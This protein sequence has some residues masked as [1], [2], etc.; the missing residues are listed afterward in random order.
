MAKFVLNPFMDRALWRQN[1]N[2]EVERAV[3]DYLSR[4]IGCKEREIKTVPVNYFNG[5]ISHPS[6]RPEDEQTLI[7]FLAKRFH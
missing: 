7:D 4:P 5:V 2:G 1:G 6:L 3:M